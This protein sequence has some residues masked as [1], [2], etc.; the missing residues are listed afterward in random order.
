MAELPECRSDQSARFD[1]LSSSERSL[2]AKGVA[3]APV[4][5]AVDILLERLEN[6]PGISSRYRAFQGLRQLS[7]MDFGTAL[8]GMPN[9]RYPKLSVLLPAMAS[10]E[11]QQ[12]WTGNFGIELLK[13]TVR[14]VE[15]L[16]DRFAKLTG[17]PLDGSRILDYGCGYGRI[18]RLLYKFT[19]EKNV[20]GVD[21]WD[22]AI[23]ICHQA[24][25]ED[26]YFV[27]DYLP[28]SLPVKWDD[29]DLIYAFSVFTHLSERATFA[30]LRVLGKYVSSR[31]VLV[32]T[33]RPP[34]Y[35][36]HDPAT[37]AAEKIELRR[38]HEVEGFAFHPH[39]RDAVDG[40]ITYGDTSLTVEWLTKHF[41]E[42]QTVATEHSP[43]D[44]KRHPGTVLTKG[45]IRYAA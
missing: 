5:D 24:R 35:W 19:E 25:L 39:V 3:Q 40:E 30:A 14:F 36:E 26:N 15:S 4:L 2:V 6:D 31:G 28:T 42:W 23:E 11:V 43:M 17:R 7:L 21:P 9:Q 29:F 16:R 20:V 45:S 41:P 13:Q 8:L 10:D 37:T 12:N 27:S 34:D 22:K 38:R 1:I 33:I 32:I 44:R 18:S